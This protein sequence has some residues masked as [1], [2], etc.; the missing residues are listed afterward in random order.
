MVG[1]SS[2]AGETRALPRHAETVVV[3]GGVGGAIVAGRLAEWS[4]AS[5]L[6]LEAGPDYGPLRD[7]RWPPELLDYTGMPV[8]SHSWGYASA[9]SAGTPNHNLD[10]A[11]VIGGCSSHNGCAAV[12]GWRG[13]YDAWGAAGNPGWDMESLRPLFER[14]SAALRVFQPDRDEVTP[15]HRACLDAGPAAGLPMIPSINDVDA[16]LGIGIGALNVS[17]NV[18]WNS[19]FAYL[20]PVRDRSHLG[21]VGNA[22]VDRVVVERGRAVAVAVVIDGALQ[23]VEAGRV[24]LAGGAFGSP[25]VLLRSGIGAADEIAR[26]GIEPVLELPGVGR[27]LQEH[28]ATGV[29]YAGT[30]ELIAAMDAFVAAGGAP[31]EEGTIVLAKSAR[32]RAGFDL[33]LYP[34]GT[35]TPDGWR[36]AIYAAVMEVRS[37]G[38]VRLSGRDPEAPPVID[39]GYFGDPEGADLA[40]LCDGVR[41]ARE[42]GAQSPVRELA[43]RELAPLARAAEIPAFVRAH[44]L[45]DYHP[46]SSCKMGPASDPLAVV[47]AGGKVHGLD[48]LFVADASIMP[49]VT[50]A[51]TN[52]PTA[53]I[54]E[55]IADLL[56]PPR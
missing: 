46:S 29:V 34:I 6:L 17:A 14:A 41:I 24:V 56:Q 37:R 25:L 49:S 22:L 10:R 19:A 42:L 48:G 40:V 23:R 39:P 51:N 16:E 53:V 50:R 5:V 32:C 1:E 9:C 31:R 54:G 11:R 15:W 28:P 43:G 12:W 20:D 45:H 36:F 7:G 26:F 13:D 8:T 35:R 52:V 2:V 44:S 55:K 27:N 18:R 30:P 3:G 33:H 4:D 38:G 21:I 47:D